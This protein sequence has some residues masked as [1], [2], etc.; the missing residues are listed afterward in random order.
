MKREYAEVVDF[1]KNTTPHQHKFFL[2]LI[3][4]KLSFF[5]TDTKELFFIEEEYIIDFNGSLLQ[6]PI[7]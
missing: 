6:I 7:R 2:E 4:D 3:S 1:W 5:N